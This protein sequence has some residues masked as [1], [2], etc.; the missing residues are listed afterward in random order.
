MAGEDEPLDVVRVVHEDVIAAPVGVVFPLCCPV[1]EY[2]WIPGWRCQL[3]HCPNDR[4][5]RGC[6]FREVL[7]APFL[8]GAGRGWT[9]WTAIVHEPAEHKLHFRL[10]NEVS[11]SLYKIEMAAAAAGGT[12]VRLDLAYHATC[13]RGRAHVAQGADRR[14]RGMLTLLSAML[15]H[16][17]ERGVSLRIPALAR[18]VLRSDSLLLGDKL[19]LARSQV[20]MLL[21]RDPDRRRVLAGAVEPPPD[22]R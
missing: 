9:T 3:L 4:V 13:E 17:C 22:P 20:S 2:A 12:R 10:D 16:Y 5:E 19:R 6:R 7:S 21:L 18:Q 11:S 14:I 8:L 1:R 15:K